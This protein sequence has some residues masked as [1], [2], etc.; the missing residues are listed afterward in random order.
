MRLL[1]LYS[2]KCNVAFFRKRSKKIVIK[3]NTKKC[4]NRLDFKMF[5]KFF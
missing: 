1:E 2:L 4:K 5:L 3:I